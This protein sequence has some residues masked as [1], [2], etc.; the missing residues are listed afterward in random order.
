MFAYALKLTYFKP[1]MFLP[2]MCLGIPLYFLKAYHVGDPAIVIPTMLIF[3]L[4]VFYAVVFGGG[5]SIEDARENKWMFPEMVNEDF[6][7]VW[8]DSIM[9]PENININ[10]WLATLPDFI[11]MII[12]V[13]LDCMLKLSATES[14]LPVKV[15]KDDE[16]RLVGKTNSLM[17][18]CGT[19]VGYMQLKFNVMNYGIIGTVT[20]RRAGVINYIFSNLYSNFW[21]MFGQTLRGSF[22]AVSKPNFESKYSFKSS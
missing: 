6:Y 4:I 8:T 7:L 22:S 3:P 5:W 13:T 14:K 12:L 11:T 1:Y 21:L 2:A 16:L 20:D 17:A 18:F 15:P 19:S 9:K 10:A